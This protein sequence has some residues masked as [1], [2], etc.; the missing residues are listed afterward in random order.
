MLL[1]FI[2]TWLASHCYMW[3]GIGLTLSVTSYLKDLVT[4]DCKKKWKSNH[5]TDQ[6]S[7][8]DDP[9]TV[10]MAN[11]S[12]LKFEIIPGFISPCIYLRYASICIPPMFFKGQHY[13]S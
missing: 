10:N 1:E 4:I 11:I 5:N 13:H 7:N 6:H 2:I 12:T 3:Y 8:D 9:K